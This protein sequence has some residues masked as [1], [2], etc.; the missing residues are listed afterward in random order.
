MHDGKVGTEQAC[1]CG[2]CE[3]V[4]C[5]KLFTVSV[6]IDGSKLGPSTKTVNISDPASF[7]Q[8]FGAVD[9]ACN[10]NGN[11]GDRF[12]SITYQCTRS[13]DSTQIYVRY[14]EDE[15]ILFGTQNIFDVIVIWFCGP[16]YGTENGEWYLTVSASV[17]PP[18]QDPP[19]DQISFFAEKLYQPEE[20]G[21]TSPIVAIDTDSMTV[22][23]CDLGGVA[24]NPC[25]V[26]V[27]ASLVPL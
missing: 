19:R 14:S 6:T 3:C 26:R 20:C 16:G 10:P 2:G 12:G 13:G 9:A 21:P 11:V 4:E 17:E 15:I 27:R 18:G 24:Q 22:G 7:F 8:C 5:N 1:C 25:P 23:S